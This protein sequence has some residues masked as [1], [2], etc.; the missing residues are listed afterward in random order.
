[1][2]GRI[3]HA[4]MTVVGS[5]KDGCPV[6]APGRNP[7]SSTFRSRDQR[8]VHHL[9]CLKKLPGTSELRSLA[10][11]EAIEVGRWVKS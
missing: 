7:V 8:K 5:R 1:M 2:D 3:K 6:C 11:T 9:A 10:S 4:E